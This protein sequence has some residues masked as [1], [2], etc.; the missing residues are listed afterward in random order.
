MLDR[1]FL[2]Q[3]VMNNQQIPG[4]LESGERLLDW[5]WES[6]NPGGFTI[7]VETTKEEENH[8]NNDKK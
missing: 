3:M 5:E 8:R 2:T 1:Q 6:N 7:V 4:P